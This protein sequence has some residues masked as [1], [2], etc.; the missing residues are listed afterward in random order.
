MLVPISVDISLQQCLGGKREKSLKKNGK[1][2][3]E[4]SV[5]VAISAAAEPLS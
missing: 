5:D 3:F 4:F 2:V 1:L